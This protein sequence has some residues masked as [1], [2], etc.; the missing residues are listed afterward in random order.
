MGQEIIS[1]NFLLLLGGHVVFFGLF[2]E[3]LLVML[4][5]IG[6]YCLFVFCFYSCLF[7]YMFRN[8]VHQI[9]SKIK[10]ICIAPFNKEAIQI[11][12]HKNTLRQD[13]KE[14]QGI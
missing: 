3:S 11:D 5:S 7:L 13:I 4:N 14:T 6:Y 10:M 2:T 8:K 9:K 1:I 12:L